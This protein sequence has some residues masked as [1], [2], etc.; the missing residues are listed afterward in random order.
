MLTSC[1]TSRK[2]QSGFTLIEIAVVLVIIGMLF[3]SFI[4]TFASRIDTT[5]RDNAKKELEEIKRVIKAYAFTK[6]P[7][8]LPCPDTNIPPDGIE[9]R[10]G[11]AC[12]A[13]AAVGTLPWITLGMGYADAWHTRYSYWVNTDYS[14]NTGFNLTTGNT[15][16]AQI[17]TRVNNNPQA[18]AENAVAVIFSRGKNSLGGISV[19]GVN[20]APIPAVGNGYDDEN[21]NADANSVFMSRIKTDVGVAAA[22]GVFDDILVWINSYELK[23]NMVEAGVLPP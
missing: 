2:H 7:P 15:G 4:G 14:I 16:S 23:A 20:Q 17:N 21:E 8:Y 5:R 9:N 19:E 6:S 1:C 13:G 18:I 10:V 22:G 12:T 11:G 3:G